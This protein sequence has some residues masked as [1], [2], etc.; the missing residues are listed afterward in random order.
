[1]TF[2]P[3]N[4]QDAMSY[5]PVRVVEFLTAGTGQTMFS[6]RVVAAKKN[7]ERSIMTGPIIERAW[8]SNAAWLRHEN[9]AGYIKGW[10]STL[11]L[12]ECHWLAM[13]LW[14]EVLKTELWSRYSMSISER[15]GEEPIDKARD[16]VAGASESERSE[17]SML[18]G[19]PD[20]HAEILAHL[21]MSPYVYQGRAN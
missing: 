11:K 3:N 6:E 15:N 1:L 10:C 5:I 14:K 12:N 4:Y 18:T 16:F 17:L 19:V 2:N 9:A 8:L 20:C 13:V 7:G 21:L